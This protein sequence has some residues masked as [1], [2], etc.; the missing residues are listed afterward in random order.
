MLAWKPW[1]GPLSIQPTKRSEVYSMFGNPGSGTMSQRW[2]RD[3]IV[4][5]HPNL[6]NQ[7]PGV[8]GKWWVKV[9]RLIEPYLREA[10][11]RA[12]AAAPEYKITRIGGQNF[13]HIR[14]DSKNPLSM[15]SWGIAVDINPRENFSKTFKAGKGPV[16]W[17]DEY[18]AIWPDGLP[19][20]FV[21]AFKSCGFAWG[22]DWDEDGMSED[23]TYYDP[24]HF[25][26]VARDGKANGV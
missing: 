23:H 13:R 9:H 11:R 1:D 25:E 21:D 18:N 4:E 24:M 3:S 14:H 17:S 5:C 7:L 19:E 6:G 2:Y 20:A 12:Q 15:H 8:P 22:S 16:A 10:L 26:W